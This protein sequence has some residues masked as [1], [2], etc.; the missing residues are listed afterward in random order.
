[1]IERPM[2]F[3]VGLLLA[4]SA[5]SQSLIPPDKLPLHL[6]PL[7]GATNV[8]AAGAGD[9]FA[10]H[11]ELAACYP[12][13][14]QLAL[15]SK[16]LPGEWVPRKESFLNPGIPTSQIRGWT[17][18]ED[19][20]SAPPTHVDHWAGEWDDKSGRILTYD[21]IYRSRTAN[22]ARC[23]LEISATQLS[24]PTVRALEARARSSVGAVP[25]IVPSRTD[26]IRIVNPEFIVLRP[27][28][29]Q[30]TPGATTASIYGRRVY[31]KSSDRILDL[32]QLAPETAHVR[33]TATGTFLV[34][35]DTTNEGAKPLRVWTSTHLNQQIGVFVDGHLIDAPI[36]KSAIDGL[37][38]LDGQFTR[39]QAEEVKARLL[40][41]GAR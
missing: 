5:A 14:P 10:V 7:P 37:I 35:V 33:Q 26:A 27:L 11:Y 34:I 36:I 32:R 17:N 3:A 1:M 8:V 21:L 6:R 41:G 2:I 29:N 30:P 22:E 18:Y 23:K 28:E 4:S 12:A 19:S 38:V 40:R 15:L 39:S 24:A 9:E 25:T 16:R 31:Y 13:L 20:T